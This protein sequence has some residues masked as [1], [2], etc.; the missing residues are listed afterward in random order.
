[1]Y[2]AAFSIVR[3]PLALALSFLLGPGVFAQE[4]LR[5]SELQQVLAAEEQVG[6]FSAQDALG[7]LRAG[8][9]DLGPDE[10]RLLDGFS[11]ADQGNLAIVRQDGTG[12]VADLSQDGTGNLAFVLQRGADVVAS[13][14]QQGT[15]NV[16]GMQLD[17]AGLTL[18]GPGAQRG[19]TQ[20]GTGN[21][22]LLE[23]AG[24]GALA[25]AVQVGDANQAVQ[26]GNVRQ[27]F[28]IQQYGSGL[29]MIIRHN[30]AQ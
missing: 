19:V 30:G 5:P 24:T 11:L 12:H 22:Y 15:G 13:A 2:T 14:R 16:I 3:L 4:D 29:S 7:Q 20:I 21:V 23:Y 9:L 8:L 1:M 6:A 26:I 27:V 28:G 10:R 25:P 17:G 18:D